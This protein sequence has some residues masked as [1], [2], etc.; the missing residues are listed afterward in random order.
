M[1]L[2]NVDPVRPLNIDIYIVH[3]PYEIYICIPLRRVGVK[4]IDPPPRHMH[5]YAPK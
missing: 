1:Y 4:I 5:T 2:A 3:R